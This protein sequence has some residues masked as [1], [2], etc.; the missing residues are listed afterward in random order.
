MP[1]R[2]QTAAAQINKNDEAAKADILRLEA[3]L[4]RMG[5]SIGSLYPGLAS[6]LE[7]KG[8]YTEPGYSAYGADD[9][10]KC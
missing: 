3:S 6:W 1:T 7:E 10:G 2:Q 8:V 4:A 9:T 5:L